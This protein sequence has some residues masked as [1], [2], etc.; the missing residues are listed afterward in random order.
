VTAADTLELRALRH[1]SGL[2]ATELARLVS[3]DP[4]SVLRWERR[5]R[6]PGPHHVRALARTLDVPPQ[7]VSGFFDAARTPAPP[8]TGLRGTTLRGLRRARGLTGA[9]LGRLVDVPASTVYNWEAGRSRIPHSRVAGIA[10]ALGVPADRLVAL[11]RNAPVAD[12]RRHLPRSPVAILRARRGLSQARAAERLGVSRST[13]R[14]WEAGRPPT[15]AAVRAMAALYGV[16]TVRVAEA[17]GV[18][19]PRHLDPSSWR[20]GD[21]PGV[22]RTL[23]EW[24]GLTQ[25]ALGELCGA[26]VTT[27]RAWENARHQPTARLRLNLE[28]VLRLPP[29]ALLLAYAAS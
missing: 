23:R 27:V 25:R 22:L 5:E 12:V 2:T 13:L 26:R 24:S 21:L 9:E 4:A 14:Q 16:P 11:L 18:A 15:L 10:R 19:F 1:A 8:Q 17:C 20:P 7:Q 6:L 29:G 28:E 3:V